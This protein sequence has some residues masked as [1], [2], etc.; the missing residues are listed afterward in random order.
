M[1][2]GLRRGDTTVNVSA[3]VLPAIREIDR[4]QGEV[5]KFKAKTSATRAEIAV[6]TNMRDLKKSAAEVEAIKKRLEKDVKFDI[7]S[8]RRRDMANLRR[9]ERELKN[10]S[11]RHASL[12]DELN[13]LEDTYRKLD[14]KLQNITQEYKRQTVELNKRK[15]VV[16]ELRLLERE[17]DLTKEENEFLWFEE[18]A[19]RDEEARLRIIKSEM[20]RTHHEIT[21]LNRDR[22]AKALR[23]EIKLTDERLANAKRMVKQYDENVKASNKLLDATDREIKRAKELDQALLDR[24]IILDRNGVNVAKLRAQ[25]A[26]LGEEYERLQKKQRSVIHREAEDMHNIELVAAKMADI[27]RKLRR[28][29][30]DTRDITWTSDDQAAKFRKFSKSLERVRVQLGLFSMNLRAF[31]SAG[32]A[33]ANIV[34]SLAAAATA[35]IGTLGAGLLGAAGLASAAV[36]GLGLAALGTTLVVVPLVKELMD[37]RKAMDAYDKAVKEHGKNSTQAENA[38][39]KLNNILGNTSEQVKGAIRG[40]GQIEKQWKKVTKA[41]R[42]AVFDSFAQAITTI[43]DLLPQFGRETVRT[44]EVASQSLNKL[45]EGMR[46]GKGRW[47]LQEL[48]ENT[49][50]ALPFLIEGMGKLAAAA[51]LIA[52][53]FSRHLEPAFAAF[54]RWS[55]GILDAVSE[56]TKLDEVVDGLMLHFKSVADFIGATGRVIYDVLAA[57]A[58][59]GRA[60]LDEM[61]EGLRGWSEWLRSADGQDTMARWFEEGIAMTK[62]LWNTLTEIGKVM[63]DIGSVTRPIVHTI[64]NAVGA[65]ASFL[66]TLLDIRGVS[67]AIKLAIAGWVGGRALSLM[68]VGMAGMGRSMSNMKNIVRDSHIRGVLSGSMM[69]GAATSYSRAA[70]TARQWKDK[71]G[72]ALKTVGKI[73]GG[74]V[75]SL[76]VIGTAAAI[77]FTAVDL[78]A[79]KSKTSTDGLNSSL[80][81]TQALLLGLSQSSDVTITA[82]AQLDANRAAVQATKDR[83]A[84][85]K[86]EGASQLEIRAARSEYNRLISEGFILEEQYKTALADTDKRTKAVAENA[87]ATVK[88]LRE[89][90]GRDSNYMHGTAGPFSLPSM[91]DDFVRNRQLL[92]RGLDIDQLNTVAA[93]M[94]RVRD[95]IL[96]TGNVSGETSAEI[97]QMLSGILSGP[98]LARFW[99][100]ANKAAGDY[101]QGVR[102]TARAFLEAVNGMRAQ[103]NMPKLDVNSKALRRSVTNA[104]AA[105][106]PESRVVKIVAQAENEKD[107]ERKL[108]K[109]ARKRRATIEA[110]AETSRAT[111]EINNIQ[112]DTLV[113]QTTAN[114]D[115][116]K[117]A[118]DN[119]NLVKR[120]PV[121]GVPG[122]FS[123]GPVGAFRRGTSDTKKVTQAARSADR[124]SA[125]RGDRSRKVTKPTYITGEESG[126]PEFVIATNPAYRTNNIRYLQMAADA[127]GL[128]VVPGFAKGGL[129]KVFRKAKKRT[130]GYNRGDLGYDNLHKEW[131]YWNSLYNTRKRSFDEKLHIGGRV[132]G[133]DDLIEPKKKTISTIERLIKHLENNML[134]PAKKA[135][136]SENILRRASKRLRKARKAVPKKPKRGNFKKGKAGTEQFQE[137]MDDYRKQADKVKEMERALKDAKSNSNQAKYRYQSLY[138]ELK[139][140]KDSHLP[141]AQM[142][143]Q[144]LLEGRIKPGG[145]RGGGAGGGAGFTEGAL[146]TARL[147][148][149]RE[150][151]SNYTAL[152]SSIKAPSYINGGGSNPAIPAGAV[153][154]SRY[155]RALAARGGEYS[156]NSSVPGG[157]TINN[158]FASGPPDA[159]TW[160]KQVAWEMSAV[161]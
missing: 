114:T 65:A 139:T 63:L 57:G 44:V 82:K 9:W 11:K 86:E 1:A 31:I 55:E 16:A 112:I 133:I 48:M 26:K 15:K 99:L 75:R 14:D 156:T 120:V 30:H 73:A 10:I 12:N 142:D 43:R 161:G 118:V 124:R 101:R 131:D 113:I 7:V 132:M 41:A 109:A 33:M 79:N 116:L 72:G 27:R 29:G 108:D 148:L 143:L 36:A 94:N 47:A 122:G 81:Q 95:S 152:S 159:L 50:E 158:T 140:L 134:P 154:V 87:S 157:V 77:G 141:D 115:P 136:N 144:E 125:Q 91:F 103:D 4:L 34:S 129:P 70:D 61:T 64:I 130:R 76:P 24:A 147:G 90:I 25:Y 46:S 52:V 121:I 128:N 151:G 42:P 35:L 66:D 123:G 39:K 49:R 145:S 38:E 93:A 60:F 110:E 153:P 138:W 111:K 104:L 96:A 56:T 71:T 54:D 85:L 119:L 88:S 160:S 62:D 2:R 13:T 78:L 8:R 19:I 59:P 102:Q 89:R 107:A 23:D 97:N 6:A 98:D 5:D 127:L 92:T 18:P 83:I 74:L 20:E 126:H 40:L 3:N 32:S 45:F 155:D 80:Q 28:L 51:G 150:F 21:K 149:M 106:V 146:N 69:A 100:N 17:R 37:A 67:E 137:A 117:T 84:L 135:A 58:G 53:S 22:Q 105:G 68:A